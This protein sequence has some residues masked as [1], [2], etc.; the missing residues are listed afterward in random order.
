MSVIGIS[1]RLLAALAL[2]GAG[3][4]ADTAADDATVIFDMD[5]IRHVPGTFGEAK[6][7]VGTVTGVPGRIGAAC[8]FTVV[9]G[10]RGGFFTAPVRPTPAWDEAAGISFFVR[11]DGSGAFGGIGYIDEA[12]R[13]FIEGWEVE[14]YRRTQVQT[15][16]GSNT[17]QGLVQ[18]AAGSNTEQGQVQT[19]VGS[20]PDREQEA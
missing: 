13:R 18:S 8:R 19:A 11:G 3:L 1:K 20:D 7:P 17:E 2:F 12:S 10:A 14:A 4:R 9:E 15:A 5:T 6:T 16:A